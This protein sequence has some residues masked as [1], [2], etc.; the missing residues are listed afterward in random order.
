LKLL[1]LGVVRGCDQKIVDI[2]A[3]DTVRL[4]ENTIVGLGHSEAV[5][6]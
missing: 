2:Q 5:S 6:H 4:I 1:D 3:E